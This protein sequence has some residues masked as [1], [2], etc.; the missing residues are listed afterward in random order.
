CAAWEQCH[1]RCENPNNHVLFH[2]FVVFLFILCY[3]DASVAKKVAKMRFFFYFC[4]PKAE[5]I[6]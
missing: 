5:I 3:F 6:Y 2:I 1:Q 4:K